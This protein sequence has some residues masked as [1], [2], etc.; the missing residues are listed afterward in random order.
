MP[1]TEIPAGAD[2]RLVVCDMDGTL[3]DADGEIP[4]GFW[5]LLE[6]MHAR[7]VSFAPASGR[8]YA[9]LE[10]MFPGADTY[11]A[12]N[13]TIVVHDGHV[14]S[15]TP[16]DR[17]TVDSVIDVVRAAAGHDLGLVV[18]GRDSAYIERADEPFREQVEK[19]YVAL[20]V[21]DDLHAVDD[22]VLKLAV[23]TFGDSTPVADE[24]F[25]P[26]RA[27]HQVVVSNT[28]W[29]DIMSTE[30]HKGHA[31]R[32]MQRAFA[33]TP[34]QTAV[35][36]D[37]LNDREMLE[38]GDLSFAMANAH[39]EVQ[40]VARY[41]APSNADGGVLTVLRRLLDDEHLTPAPARD[42]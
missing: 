15:T 25:A 31:V 42:V 1:W 27:H 26:F 13:G 41:L 30:A 22:E 37:Y 9:T 18:C 7:G 8:Q 21:L 32:A 23:Y 2:V 29:I 5:P 10:R 38:A 11:I 4:A 17:D 12:E 33:I 24:V 39:P 40:A 14:V 34:A 6:T 28:N 16:V 3:L 36:G 19:Y 20:D 35:F